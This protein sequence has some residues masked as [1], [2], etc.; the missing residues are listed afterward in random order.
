M[1]NPNFIYGIGAVVLPDHREEFHQVRR[2]LIESTRPANIAEQ[3]VVDQLLHAR[4]ELLRVG[5]NAS[6]ASAEPCLHAAFAR[7]SRNWQR[8]L[9]LL[10]SLQSARAAAELCRVPVDKEVPPAANLAQVPRPKAPTR[11]FEDFF[12]QTIAAGYYGPEYFDPCYDL[13]PEKEAA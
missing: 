4:W 12:H 9:R 11:S 3:V 2:D 13:N 7:A 6:H 1:F 10:T 8:A 5:H